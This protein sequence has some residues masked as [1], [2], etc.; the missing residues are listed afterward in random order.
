MAGVLLPSLLTGACLGGGGRRF[1]G[2]GIG[3]RLRGR[4]IGGLQINRLVGGCGGVKESGQQV[5]D[6]M[7]M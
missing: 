4:D 2:S 6:S 1:F 3:I 7:I 5:L